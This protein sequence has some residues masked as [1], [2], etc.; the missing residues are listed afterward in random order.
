VTRVTDCRLSK[1]VLCW[2]VDDGP[3]KEVTRLS[4]EPVLAEFPAAIHVRRPDRVEP[5][6]PVRPR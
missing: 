4:F 6:G 1:D 3:I 2:N 5:V